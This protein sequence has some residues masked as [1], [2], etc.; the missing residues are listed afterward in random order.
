MLEHLFGSKTRLRLLKTFFR[1]PLKAYYVRELTRMLDVQ[2]NA[3]RRELELLVRAGLIAEKKGN[4][5][6]E[7][8]AQLRKYY[9]LNTESILY[10]ELQALLIK[11]QTMGEEKFV[12]E[13]KEKAGDI[14]LLLLTGR[15]TGDKRA[16]SDVLLVGAIKE[17]ILERLMKEYEEEFGTT[18]NYT[19]MTEKEFLDRRQV[20]DKFLYSL[21]EA[22]HVLA[23]DKLKV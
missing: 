12:N 9:G 13:L 22:K 8:S 16:L 19:I 23:V 1:D 20:M 17:L 21:F 18:V 10:P 7:G 6:A 15:F 4:A 14:R 2:I 3:I 5:A 11:A